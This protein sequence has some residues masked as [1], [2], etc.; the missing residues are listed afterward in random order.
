M[1]LNQTDADTLVVRKSNDLI[2]SKYKSTLLENQIMAIAM[3]RIE[4]DSNNEL[5]ATIYPGELQRLTGRGHNL[6]TELRIAATAMIGHGVV[7][8]DGCGNFEAFSLV[9]RAE[10]ENGVFQ[11]HFNESIR[12]H[13]LGLKANYTTMNLVVLNS[14]KKN[15]S[16]RIYELLR[17]ELYKCDPAVN[18]GGVEVIYNISELKF[19]LS[20]A[21]MDEAVVQRELAKYKAKKANVDWDHLYDIVPEKSYAEWRDLRRNV[22]LPAQKELK[23]KSD[24]RFDFSG[25]RLGSRYRRIRF[26]VY[27]N[28]PNE[29]F[30]QTFAEKAAVLEKIPNESDH[31]YSLCEINHTGFFKKYRGHNRLTDEDLALILEKANQDEEAAERAIHM[32]DRQPEIRNYIG[33]ILKCVENGYEEVAVVSGSAETAERIQNLQREI[34]SDEVQRNVWEKVKNKDDFPKFLDFI[35]LPLEQYEYIYD[36]IS[37]RVEMYYDWKTGK[38]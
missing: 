35:N 37:E 31:Q 27:P 30:Q 3:T 15:A 38:L 25:I 7:I 12:P 34:H 10:Y 33:W 8:E 26:W 19:M 23:E 29:D 22:L 1:D 11:L 28:E 17:K 4:L 24:I 13:L 21:N 18:D 14:F 5:I 32:A 2:G 36:S 20:L 16:F 6:Y 9:K